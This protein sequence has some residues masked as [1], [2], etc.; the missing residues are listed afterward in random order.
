MKPKCIIGNKLILRNVEVS[1][2]EF[3]LKLRLDSNKNKFLNSTSNDLEQQIQYLKTYEQDNNSVYFII[4][5]KEH[6]DIGTIRLY[7]PQENSFC[8]GSWILSQSAQNYAAIE[9]ALILYSFALDYL[10]FKKSHFDVR[11]ENTKVWNF[12]ERFGAKL[13]NET[14]IDRFYEIS[15]TSISES[16]ERYKKF[17]PQKIHVKNA[18]NS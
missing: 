5:D 7:D 18:E 12:H 15:E 9:S 10:G 14:E 13:I 3:I 16:L 11:Q 2:A 4:E 17:L 6:G 1:D 8:W